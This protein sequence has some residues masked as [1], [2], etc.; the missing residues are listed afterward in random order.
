VGPG[1]SPEQAKLSAAMRASRTI[2]LAMFQYANDHGGNYPSGRSSTEIFQ[3][4]L[5]GKYVDD[6]AIFFAPVPGKTP[7]TSSRLR[8]N[9]V[10]FDTTIPLN[11]NSPEGTPVVFLTGFRVTYNAGGDALM[12]KPDAS[13][14]GGTV[15]CYHC[16][17]A[18]VIAAPSS[19]GNIDIENFVPRDF[20]P[21]EAQFQ[22]LTPD[23]PLP[24]VK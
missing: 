2:E 22:Q 11:G 7:A 10:A 4:L 13:R 20:I 1:Y 12:L 23:G 18:F 19:R 9:N 3:K 6:P 15:V 21:G 16:Q 5:D 14:L 17:N 24:P 8:P